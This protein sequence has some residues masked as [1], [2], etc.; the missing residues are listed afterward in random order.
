MGMYVNPKDE[1]KEHFL[2]REGQMIEKIKWDD[3][4]AGRLPVVLM[5]NG[6]FT[7]AGIAYK[8]SELDEFTRPTDHRTKVMFLVSIDKLIPTVDE[9]DAKKLSGMLAA[10]SA[11]EV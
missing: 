6:P 7:A 10:N 2:E 4:P 1:T 11:K 5:D 3:V 8:A 9:Y